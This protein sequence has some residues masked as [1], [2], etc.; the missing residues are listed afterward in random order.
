MSAFNE[1]FQTDTPTG[2]SI[3]S[4]IDIFINA[5]T[6]EALDERYSL[7]HNSLEDGGNDTSFDNAQGRHV[8]GMVGCLG[9]GTSVQRDALTTAERPPGIGAIWENTDNGYLERYTSSGWV[10]WT[11]GGT[12]TPV[13]SIQMW[14][15][16]T[17]PDNWLL[18]EGQEINRL[19]YPTLFSTLG[20]TYGD[21][22]TTTTFNLPD[23]R[24]Q[25]VR[26]WDNTR[27]LDPNAGD[28]TDRGDGTTG[29]EVGTIQEDEFDAHV[30]GL[31][32][33]GIGSSG[34]FLA[35]ISNQSN[36]PLTVTTNQTGGDETRPVNIYMAY[37]IRA[38]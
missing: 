37:I 16:D 15:T 7:E 14:P 18:C 27:G 10:Q 34:S 8:A 3:A 11:A 4:D 31:T 28:R 35:S 26:G 9:V 5:Q 13:G 20:V 24:G 1:D 2:Q 29:D 21:G 6:K 23:M 12:I 17:P 22:D 36:D 19:D 30:H 32:S 38:I 25:F 33:I